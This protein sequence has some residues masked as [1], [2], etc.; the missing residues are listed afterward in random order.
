MLKNIIYKLTPLIIIVLLCIPVVLPYFHS[1]Y[2]PTHDGEWAVVRLADMFRTIRDL[3]FPPRYSGA[4]NF[5]YGYPLFNFTY[6]FPYYLGLVLY[7]PFHSFIASIKSIFALSV[8]LSAIFMYLASNELWK[9]K[10]SAVISSI[11]YVYLPYRM[12]DL[13]VR[14]SIG[15]SLS[16]A[17]FPLIFY[18]TL[19]LF[20]SPFSRVTVTFLTL[21]LA[22]LVM[23]HNIMTVLFL[24]VLIFFGILRIIKEKRW[25]V[26]Q[27]FF[28]CL[29][30]GAGL[31]FFFW[32]PALFEKNNILLS[33]IPIANR[34]LYF[35]NIQQLLI[36]SWGFAS[37]TESGGFSYQLGI[38]Q[39]IAVVLSLI[40]LIVTFIRSKLVQTPFKFYAF[41]LFF[42][43]T[44]CL[45]FLFSVTSPIWKGLPLLKEI[46]YPWTLLSQLGFIS[47]LLAGFLVIQHKYIKYFLIILSVVAIILVLPYAKPQSYVDRT[48]SYYITNEATTTSSHE[49]M[50]VWVKDQP[51]EHYKN[52]VEIIGGNAQ[53]SNLKF[54][55]RSLK[56]NYKADTDTVFQI[57]TIYYPGWK[58]YLNGEMIKINYDNPKGVMQIGVS[59]YRDS[60]SLIFDETLPRFI[61]D[62][63]SVIS[64]GIILFIF[65][66]PLL[67]F[68]TS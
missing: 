43:Y 4:L 6:P 17:L 28:L 65:L 3:Q 35:V 51:I 32:F 37:P 23:T 53:I 57:N 44:V 59:R 12:V 16:F 60:V 19:K 45:L 21:S 49:L 14:G 26:L 54:N 5:G 24:P 47:S 46:N 30:L 34:N 25:D 68:K 8:F 1:G 63:V 42:M 9:D 36:P 40:F 41:I 58:A 13:F 18:L 29:L 15:E 48:D 62:T 22:L 39:S 7:F 56:F 11:F 20:A 27:S 67:L 66:R 50:P 55:S 31:S 52:K 64:I 10:T 38:P 61:A 2:F 33:K